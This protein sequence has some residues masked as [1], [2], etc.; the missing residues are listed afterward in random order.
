MVP[1][2]QV[3]TLDARFRTGR[4]I[5]AAMVISVGLYAFI[6]HQISP[7]T[8]DHGSPPDLLRWLRWVLYGYG[9]ILLALVLAALRVLSLESRVL[10]L[11]TLTEV[12]RRSGPEA[13]L[14]ELQRRLLVLLVIAEAPAVLG[15]IL[16]FLGRD[17]F[18][19]YVLA[20]PSLLC[21]V[22]LSPRRELWEEVARAG[23]R[24]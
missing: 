19:F 8:G 10:R 21:L 24:A 12:A 23:T 9:A 22:I 17:L 4:I 18:D 6:A 2:A 13:A 7:L 5:H 20:V 14:S 16:F 3:V 15:L 11:P 1:G